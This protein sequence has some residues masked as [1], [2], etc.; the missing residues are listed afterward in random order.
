MAE[1]NGAAEAVAALSSSSIWGGFTTAFS[2]SKAAPSWVLQISLSFRIERG[3][4]D[5][6][7]YLL[8]KS[9]LTRLMRPKMGA[10]SIFSSMA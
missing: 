9:R 10:C 2:T 8:S 6:S 4:V 5:I 1:G 7:L 3:D